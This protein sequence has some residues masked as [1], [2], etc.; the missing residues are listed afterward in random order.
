M[1]LMR[2]DA[3]GWWQG[4]SERR[5]LINLYRRAARRSAETGSTDSTRRPFHQEGLRLARGLLVDLPNT[6]PLDAEREAAALSRFLAALWLP[7]SVY[8]PPPSCKSTSRAPK[9]AES[10]STPSA[11]SARS[12]RTAARSS[13]ARSPSSGRRLR[14]DAAGVPT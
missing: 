5:L 13:P 8:A 1:D 6:G 7:P 14:M 10:T 4:F 12:L 2:A 11:A 9:P 3:R